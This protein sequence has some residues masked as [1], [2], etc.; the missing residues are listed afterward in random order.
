MLEGF[1]VGTLLW[2]GP[3]AIAWIILGPGKLAHRFAKHH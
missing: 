1:I 3:A 2:V